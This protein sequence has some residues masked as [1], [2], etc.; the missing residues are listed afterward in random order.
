[1]YTGPFTIHGPIT[2]KFFSTDL[3]GNVEQVNTQQVTDQTVVSM[4]FDDQYEDQ[5]LYA[6][7]L[8]QAHNMTGTYYV[9]T[10]DSDAGFECCMSWSQLGTLQ[11]QGNDIGSHTIDHPDLTTLS[12]SDMTSEICGSRQDMI[13]HGITDPESFAYPFGKHNPTVESVVQQCGFNNARVGGGISNSNFTPTAPYIETI[14]P[15]DPYALSTIAVDGASPM[16]LS[17]LESFVNAA[18]AHGG[19]WLPITFHDVCD[20]SA[21]DFS[22]CMS[23]YGSVQDTVFGQ[24]LDWLVGAGQPGGAPAGVVVKNVCQVMNCP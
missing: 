17:D 6:A 19:G 15:K 20:A 10:S 4:T 24:F 8:M 18:A 7:P 9:I 11:A 22:D 12:V 21:A 2:I 16:N 23:K 5:W 3:V 14:P 1:V 13:S